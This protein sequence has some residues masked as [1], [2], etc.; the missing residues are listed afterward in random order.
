MSTAEQDTNV[1]PW[2]AVEYNYAY[3]EHAMKIFACPEHAEES[4]FF[5]RMY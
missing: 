2:H 5:L 4:K 3:L 1:S